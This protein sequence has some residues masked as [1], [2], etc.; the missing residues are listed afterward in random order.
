M[1]NITSD[2]MDNTLTAASAQPPSKLKNAAEEFEAMLLQEMLKPLRSKEDNWSGDE[3][4]DSASD[5]I[6][7]FGCE[8]V[9]KAISARGGLGIAKQV[10]RQVAAEQQKE[11]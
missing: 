1:I 10:I 4:S 5:T 9:A 11:T 7:G 3:K 6:S 8:A 2:F